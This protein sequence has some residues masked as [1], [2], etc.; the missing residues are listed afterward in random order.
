MKSQSLAQ[1]KKKYMGNSSP[2]PNQVQD[3]GSPKKLEDS[4]LLSF[5]EERP[6]PIDCSQKAIG[7]EKE[8]SDTTRGMVYWES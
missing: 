3:I 5:A 1:C 4:L 7:L 6:A 8:E 2:R